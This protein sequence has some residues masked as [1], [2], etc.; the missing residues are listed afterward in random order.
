MVVNPV[1]EAT[2][3]GGVASLAQL[4]RSRLKISPRITILVERTV[5]MVDFITERFAVVKSGWRV[6]CGMFRRTNLISVILKRS[7][8]GKK[9]KNA[10]KIPSMRYGNFQKSN[11]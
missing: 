7:V 5:F 4:L 3:W 11:N 10:S 9:T 1:A 6:N 8:P 2:G